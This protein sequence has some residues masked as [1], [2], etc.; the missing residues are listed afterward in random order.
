VSAAL[1]KIRVVFSDGHEREVVVGGFA[2]IAAKRVYGMD[3]LKIGDP[4]PVL[5]GVWIELDGPRPKGES[6]DLFDEWLKTVDGFELVQPDEGDADE[7]PP[8][9]ESSGSSPFSPPTSE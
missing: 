9:A 3:A 8:P 1:T 4:E 6:P 2:Q 5:Y 7:D